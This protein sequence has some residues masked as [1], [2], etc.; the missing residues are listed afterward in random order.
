MLA[1]F[2]AALALGYYC[3]TLDPT[4]PANALRAPSNQVRMNAFAP[5]HYNPPY[6]TSVPNLGY[7][8]PAPSQQQYAPPPGPP[9]Q[10]QG[11]FDDRYSVK[12]PGY[13]VGYADAKDMDK[14][15]DPFADFEA[16]ERDVTS[17][18]GPGGRDTFL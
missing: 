14:K 15:D 8:Y 12:A 1:V 13:G 16:G 9:P 11:P 2:F 7:A 6:N 3:Q 18:P 5:P 10:F 17:R 4:S